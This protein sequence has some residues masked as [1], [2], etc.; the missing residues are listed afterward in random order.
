M[1]EEKI[2]EKDMLN[3]LLDK[4]YEEAWEAKQAGKRSAGYHRISHRSFWRRWV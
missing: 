3:R 4:H 2:K 1:S